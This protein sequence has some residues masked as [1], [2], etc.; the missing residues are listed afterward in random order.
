MDRDAAKLQNPPS[1]LAPASDNETFSETLCAPGI[2]TQLL[3]RSQKLAK[4][5]FRGLL[6]RK[7]ELHNGY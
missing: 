3:I 7:I 1:K 2:E 5:S 6:V 4:D